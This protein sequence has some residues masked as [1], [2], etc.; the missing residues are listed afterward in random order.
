MKS[1]WQN[2]LELPAGVAVDDHPIRRAAFA[3]GGANVVFGDLWAPG[4]HAIAAGA[5]F[6]AQG[7]PDFRDAGIIRVDH[8]IARRVDAVGLGWRA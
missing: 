1:Y 6:R 5:G 2:L 4:A 8:Q 7:Q 3:G